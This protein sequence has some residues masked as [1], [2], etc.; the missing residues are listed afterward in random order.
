MGIIGWIIF[1]LVVGAIAR[2]LMPGRQPM[3]IILTMLLG[4][5]GSFVGGFIGTMLSGE[6]MEMANPSGWIGAI[7]GALLL[8]FLYGM[9]ARRTV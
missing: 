4:V 1:G 2:F 7:L 8:L 3:G 6:P 5:A 9:T